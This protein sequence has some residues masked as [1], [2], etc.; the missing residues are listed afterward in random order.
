MGRGRER[1][2]AEERRVSV[3]RRSRLEEEAAFFRLSSCGHRYRRAPAGASPLWHGSCSLALLHLG[4]FTAACGRA[5]TIIHVSLSIR[6]AT[7][8]KSDV[9]EREM[10]RENKLVACFGAGRFT[11]PRTREQPRGAKKMRRRRRL[12][13]VGA[14][15]EDGGGERGGS[16]VNKK[17]F[18]NS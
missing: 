5:G 11:V 2:A 10:T 7:S 8:E 15:E 13:E 14:T 17:Y 16:Q 18:W 6:R 12:G 9:P 4:I 3:T 1:G